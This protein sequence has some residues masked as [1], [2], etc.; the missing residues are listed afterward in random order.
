MS[1]KGEE[2]RKIKVKGGF[3]GPR[4]HDSPFK[5][6]KVMTIVKDNYVGRFEGKKGMERRGNKVKFG[7]KKMKNELMG[8]GWRT[9]GKKGKQRRKKRREESWKRVKVES[10]SGSRK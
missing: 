5:K 4:R 1:R 9:T 8:E 2:E 3:I 7:V 10:S 6:V